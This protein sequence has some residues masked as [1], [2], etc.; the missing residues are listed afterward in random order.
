[1]PS[2]QLDKKPDNT[3]VAAL[4][5]VLVISTGVALYAALDWMP[6]AKARKL[7]NPVPATA[8]AIAVGG[9]IYD[10]RCA[11][12]H[13]EKGDGKGEKAA[14]LSVEPTDFTDGRAMSRLT[15]GQLFFEITKGR[16]PM[17]EF[18]T[19]LNETERWE[20]VDYIRTFAA[21]PPGNP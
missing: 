13:G 21:K 10:H 18:K 15:D 2:A 8:S 6:A 17:P 20:A 3:R 19:K 1:M 7:K 16:S 9:E 12:C 14:E 4:F 5:L 11:R